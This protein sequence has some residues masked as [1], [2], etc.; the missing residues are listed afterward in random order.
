MSEAALIILTEPRKSYNQ[1]QLYK[2]QNRLFE[3]HMEH[4]LYIHY[5]GTGSPSTNGWHL[6][7]E[8][9]MQRLY[10]ILGG[11]GSYCGS[12]GQLHP[13]QKGFLYLFPYNLLQRFNSDPSDPVR[14]LFFDFLSTPPVIAPSPICVNAAG[15][16]ELKDA[17]DLTI[18]LFQ[19]RPR[20]VFMESN[21]C[22][23]LLRLILS[24]TEEIQPLPFHTDEVICRS[25]ET[26]QR[27]YAGPLTVT[28]LADEAG[29]EQNYFIRRFRSIMHQTPYAY[30]RN[31]RLMQAR[32]LLR[33]GL[34]MD[35]A[36]LKVGYESSSSLARAL[37]QTMQA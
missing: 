30:L 5:C 37:R 14:H 2:N 3:V 27:S 8:I 33:T 28:Q 10:Y 24:L 32:N 19:S 7:R 29:Y 9:E 1:N 35:E 21:L 18:R 4:Q 26:I 22:S 31:Y 20:P 11:T 25:L 36:A 17:L 13:F 12:D 6:D 15:A 16:A 34:S 23:S